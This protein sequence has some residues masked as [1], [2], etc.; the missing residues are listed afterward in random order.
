MPRPR[1]RS[2]RQQAQQEQQAQESA[3][4]QELQEQDSVADDTGT[5]S[6]NNSTDVTATATKERKTMAEALSAE[7]IAELLANTRG[8]GEYAT[9]LSEFLDSDEAGIKVDLENGTLAG[10]SVDKA[11]TG[12]NNAR[13]AVNKEDGTPKIKGGADVKV[14]RSPDKT[15]VFLINKAKVTA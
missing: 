3:Q 6:A 7:Q 4:S 5:D 14:V 11:F 1:S 9:Y 12:L 10:K 13:T 2:S 15:A 8:R